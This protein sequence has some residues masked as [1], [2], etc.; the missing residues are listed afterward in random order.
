[1][2]VKAFAMINV[3]VSKQESDLQLHNTLIKNCIIFKS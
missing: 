2:L 3:N 1:M